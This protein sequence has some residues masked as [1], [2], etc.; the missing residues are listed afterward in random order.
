M[1]IKAIVLG[2]VVPAILLGISTCLMKLSLRHGVSISTHLIVV[3]ATVL[4]VGVVATFAAGK[5]Q[6]SVPAGFASAGMGVVW[7]CS[8]I[9]MAYGMSKLDLPV[10]IVAPISN[11]NALVAVLLSAVLFKEWET[12]DVTKVLIGTCLI[13]AGASVVSVADT[14]G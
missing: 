13:V 8:V 5:W 4:L 11:S 14:Q 7:A 10:S 2:G 1:D 12:L 6:L 3:G 9:M